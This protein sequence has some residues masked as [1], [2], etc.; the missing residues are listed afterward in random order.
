MMSSDLTVRG[1]G[2]PVEYI[3]ADIQSMSF[4]IYI[5]LCPLKID[6]GKLAFLIEHEML[7]LYIPV[8]VPTLVKKLQRL[9][10]IKQ[11]K[12]KR[13]LAYCGFVFLHYNAVIFLDFIVVDTVY[14]WPLGLGNVLPQ[15]IV[16]VNQ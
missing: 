10:N 11:N 7:G 6:H 15:F 13:E 16:D 14:T 3:I 8:Q 5:P 4:D 9:E 2:T 1:E 12:P